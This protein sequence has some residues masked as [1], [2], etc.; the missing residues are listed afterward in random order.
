MVFIL[1]VVFFFTAVGVVAAYHGASKISESEKILE[2]AKAEYEN[3]INSRSQII[4]A[5]QNSASKYGQLQTQAKDTVERLV[6]FIKHIGGDAE[7]NKLLILVGFE[8]DS[9]KGLEE[10]LERDFIAPRVEASI[11]LAI[12]TRPIQLSATITAVSGIMT[13]VKGDEA[14]KGAKEYQRKV[15]LEIENISTFQSHLKHIQRRLSEMSDLVKGIHSRT[16]RGLDELES[17]K[18][19]CTREKDLE[20]FQ[21]VAALAKALVELVKIPIL[22]EDGNLNPNLGSIQAKYREI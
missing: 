1:P 11:W 18:F 8:C 16:S 10:M 15:K 7:R 6:S 14:L 20:K 13:N 3:A 2:D 9:S 4:S 17:V 19:D 22:D 12:A 21:Q 5:L